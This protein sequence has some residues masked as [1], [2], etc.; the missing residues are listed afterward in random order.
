MRHHPQY[1][2]T[3]VNGQAPLRAQGVHGSG[4][5]SY[6]AA[7]GRALSAALK[8][9]CGRDQ[10]TTIEALADATQVNGRAVR[11]FLYDYD[12]TWFLLGGGDEGIYLC[13]W[14]D[15]ADSLSRRIRSQ[16]KT[17]QHRLDRREQFAI[18]LPAI[19]NGLFGER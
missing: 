13:E 12:G 1:P 10:A 14:A 19:Q 6:T 4:G 3:Q 18:T 17:M 16:I 8:A 7:Q 2:P 11:Q 5:R 9:H 15:E